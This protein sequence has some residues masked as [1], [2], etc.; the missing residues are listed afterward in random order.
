MFCFRI[1][2]D[3]EFALSAIEKYKLTALPL[4]PPLVRQ[5]AQS[6]LTEKY[7]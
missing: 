2:R 4:V 5:L 6:P 7:D 1:G 3:L